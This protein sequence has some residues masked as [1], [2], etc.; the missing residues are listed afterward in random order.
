MKHIK[1]STSAAA[2]PVLLD[3]S[4][5]VSI[6][7]GM[8]LTEEQAAERAAARECEPASKLA[9]SPLHRQIVMA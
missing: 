5:V 8:V 9:D 2:T 7:G 4:D 1:K 6:S 3:V